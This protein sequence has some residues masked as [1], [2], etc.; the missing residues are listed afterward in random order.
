MTSVGGADS[1]W[2]SELV[3]LLEAHL[4]A[5]SSDA[6]LR[7]DEAAVVA[8]KPRLDDA[9]LAEDHGFP[10]RVR[11]GHRGDDVVEAELHATAGLNRR[12]DGVA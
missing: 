4:P 2:A 12:A 9:A 5:G 3:E 6:V 1:R 10:L 11:T 8:L 7:G